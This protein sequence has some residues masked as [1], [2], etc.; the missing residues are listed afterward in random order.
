M[1]VAILAERLLAVALFSS[2][3]GNPR[4]AAER[5]LSRCSTVFRSGEFFVPLPD[6]CLLCIWS[7]LMKKLEKMNRSNSMVSAVQGACSTESLFD[8]FPLAGDLL[9]NQGHQRISCDAARHRFVLVVAGGLG[10]HL[11]L[12]VIFPLLLD[13]SVRWLL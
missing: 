2:G 3:G 1:E 13:L 4:R 8:D 9:P 12:F 7:Q 6:R 11:A 5:V 10:V